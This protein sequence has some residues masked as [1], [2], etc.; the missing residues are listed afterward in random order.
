MRYL[1]I[2]NNGRHGKHVPSKNFPEPAI[3]WSTYSCATYSPLHG[4]PCIL[5]TDN[6]I[7]PSIQNHFYCFLCLI[8]LSLYKTFPI[9]KNS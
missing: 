5:M 3:C 9:F 4:E 1:C 7:Q 6:F 2:L 8:L